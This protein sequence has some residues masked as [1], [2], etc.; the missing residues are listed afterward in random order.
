MP[1]VTCLIFLLTAFYTDIYSAKVTCLLQ[2]YNGSNPTLAESTSAGSIELKVEVSAAATSLGA[3]GSNLA[4]I[5]PIARESAEQMSMTS[6]IVTKAFDAGTTIDDNLQSGQ[7]FLS[8]WSPLLEQVEL[9]SNLVDHLAEVAFFYVL[10]V[11]DR[12]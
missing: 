5:I 12:D 10:K 8:V 1:H 2:R 3:T 9:F 11:V 4:E 7:D 6:K